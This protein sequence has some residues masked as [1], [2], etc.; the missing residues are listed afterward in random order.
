MYKGEE[1]LI[2][3]DGKPAARLVPVSKDKPSAEEIQKTID[4]FRKHF[5]KY[6]KSDFRLP[7][8]TPE[9]RK[10][11]KAYIKKLQKRMNP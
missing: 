6:K 3:K 11:D 7:F 5:S 1:F 9:W 2:E 4:E 10:R 8:H